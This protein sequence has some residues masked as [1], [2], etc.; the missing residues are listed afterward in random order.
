MLSA[1]RSRAFGVDEWRVQ[2]ACEL[3]V[4]VELA[5][6]GHQIQVRG[7]AASGKTLLAAALAGRLACAPGVTLV[8][9]EQLG[10]AL[11]DGTLNGAGPL[12]VDGTWGWPAHRWPPPQ[13]PAAT[14]IVDGPDLVDRSVDVHVTR[15][16][17][18]ITRFL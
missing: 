10:R 11:A 15:D 18:K 8:A 14:V 4:L 9:T 5:R 7:A 6:S 3:G 13:R 1:S 2:F 12:I 16:E 17:V